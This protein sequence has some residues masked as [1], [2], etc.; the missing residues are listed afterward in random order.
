VI[1]LSGGRFILQLHNFTQIFL[2]LDWFIYFFCFA[3]MDLLRK[4]QLPKNTEGGQMLKGSARLTS[5]TTTVVPKLG[6]AYPKWC[7]RNLKRFGRFLSVQD[8]HKKFL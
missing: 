4:S 5:S 7:G 3:K 2:Q 8:L 1:L 6:Y